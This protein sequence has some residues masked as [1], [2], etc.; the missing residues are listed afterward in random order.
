MILKNTKRIKY[1]QNINNLLTILKSVD[2]L[3]ITVIIKIIK[4]TKNKAKEKEII[5]MKNEKEFMEHEKIIKELK[6][7]IANI[8]EV[9]SFSISLNDE[10]IY[11][12]VGYYKAPETIFDFVTKEFYEPKYYVLDVTSK[13]NIKYRTQFTTFGLELYVYK[14]G[15]SKLCKSIINSIQHK[16]NIQR[17]MIKMDAID[18][19]LL[20]AY[21]D[22]DKI[23]EEDKRKENKEMN[24][25][26]NRTLEGKSDDYMMGVSCASQAF[27]EIDK[28]RF[29]KSDEYDVILNSYYKGFEIC[30]AYLK[31]TIQHEE[32]EDITYMIVKKILDDIDDLSDFF[33]GFLNG[34]AD[35]TLHYYEQGKKEREE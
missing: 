27:S 25:E 19:A 3:K 31:G 16:F 6:E 5:I 2:K 22:R 32:T 7:A 34:Y 14:K 26:E 1:Y 8:D 12:M 28:G 33:D 11:D 10:P 30:K 21:E 35:A 15:I 24:N 29:R 20:N 18:K 17:K 13:D 23:I 4:E 9:K